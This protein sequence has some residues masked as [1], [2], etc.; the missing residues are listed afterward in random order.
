MNQ[1]HLIVM[2]LYHF[3]VFA[4]NKP[5]SINILAIRIVLLLFN[6][7][8]FPY[9]LIFE[10]NKNIGTNNIIYLLHYYCPSLQIEFY[11]VIF[12]SF[13]YSLLTLSLKLSWN[14]SNI[15][16]NCWI[17]LEFDLLRRYLDNSFLL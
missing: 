10:V 9:V 4:Q 6:S 12:P 2:A 15:S 3:L 17:S 16:L 7:F 14:A 1:R 5:F 13:F 11:L 8:L